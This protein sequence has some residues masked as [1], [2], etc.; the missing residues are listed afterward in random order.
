MDL[1]VFTVFCSYKTLAN[2]LKKFLP[3][4]ISPL[5]GAFIQ[6]RDMHDNIL[7]THKILNSSL[8]NQKTRD[9]DY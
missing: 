7:V 5:Q 4:V 6:S 2:R 1:L 3:K 8:E 9:N